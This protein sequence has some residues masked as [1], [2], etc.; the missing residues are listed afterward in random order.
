MHVNTDKVKRNKK[1]KTQNTNC[2]YVYIVLVTILTHVNYGLIIVITK[3][4]KD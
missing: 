2:Y 4:V 1:V 3:P